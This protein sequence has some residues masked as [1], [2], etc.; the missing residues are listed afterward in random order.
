MKRCNSETDL[1]SIMPMG[2][3]TKI[4]P[5]ITK[6]LS[7]AIIPLSRLRKSIRR[8]S[9]TSAQ[10]SNPLASIHESASPGQKLQ[11]LATP[12]QNP[13]KLTRKM[14]R[15]TMTKFTSIQEVAGNSP[16]L[17]L[18]KSARRSL[19]KKSP[20]PKLIHD[21]TRTVPENSVTNTV[22]DG[23]SNFD[24]PRRITRSNAFRSKNALN[25]SLNYSFNPSENLTRGG[26]S[27]QNQAENF[28]NESMTSP[29]VTKRTT[30]FRNSCLEKRK[31]VK[32]IGHFHISLN[33]SLA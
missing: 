3:S 6:Q 22:L 27:D 23:R 8:R 9:S 20:T 32:S 13:P 19:Q 10:K 24:T 5:S 1:M 26:M 31:K 25:R 18:K 7:S 11:N 21:C 29:S 4:H 14:R 15:K 17:P 28:L 2:Q 12:T 16:N 30:S 33:L